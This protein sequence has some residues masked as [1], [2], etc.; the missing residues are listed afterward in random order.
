MNLYQQSNVTGGFAG[1]GARDMVRQRAIASYTDNAQNR[2]SSLADT[3]R[4]GLARQQAAQQRT[5]QRRGLGSQLSGLDIADKQRQFMFDNQQGR[6]S[7]QL[8]GIQ[9]ELG[10]DGF[11]QRAFDSRMQGIDITGRQQSL[12]REE[13]IFNL[14]DDYKK[15]VRSRLIDIIRG[16]GD[17]SPFK[18]TEQEKIERGD[19]QR[20][21]YGGMSAYDTGYGGDSLRE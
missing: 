10:D 18:L 2:I 14:R 1:S 9:S 13:S 15:D 5:R 21:Q 12:G 20:T 3:R 6:V 16:G 19:F 8:E 17:L 7:S 4:I 11:L